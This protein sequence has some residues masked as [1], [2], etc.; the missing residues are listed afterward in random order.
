MARSLDS[1]HIK[2]NII[3]LIVSG[4]YCDALPPL[5][6]FSHKVFKSGDKVLIIHI[7]NSWDITLCTEHQELTNNIVLYTYSIGYIISVIGTD[8][9]NNL[10]KL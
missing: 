8:K 5:S 3:H 9:T 7:V 1:Y 10:E 2:N 4:I 6:D